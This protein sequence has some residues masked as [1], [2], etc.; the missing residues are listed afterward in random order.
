MRKKGPNTVKWDID[1]RAIVGITHLNI[2]SHS[3]AYPDIL[4]PLLTTV[5]LLLHYMYS[6][7]YIYIT[8]N[9]L[10]QKQG[11]WNWPLCHY[12]WI[13]ECFPEYKRNKNIWSSYHY[14]MDNNHRIGIH[15]NINPYIRTSHARHVACSLSPSLPARASNSKQGHIS[16]FMKF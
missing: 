4:F 14:E 7:T 1:W 8:V 11:G 10:S 2:H 6:R 12:V 15:I 5:S 16:S 13:F 3:L 9:E